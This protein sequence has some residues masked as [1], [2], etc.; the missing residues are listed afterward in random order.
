[1]DVSKPTA[2]SSVMSINRDLNV[3][4]ILNCEVLCSIRS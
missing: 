2:A 3:A 1:V 4:T